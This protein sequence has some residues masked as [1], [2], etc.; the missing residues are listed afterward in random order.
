MMRE[1][2]SEWRE[3]SHNDRTKYA[4]GMRRLNVGCWGYPI[5]N[6]RAV[7]LTTKEGDDNSAYCFSKDL[8]KLVSSFR[9]DGYDLEYCGVLE[10][11][12]VKHLLHWHGL[13]RIA[14]GF[15]VSD[16]LR[17]VR[18]TLGDRWNEYHGAFA[19]KIVPV[20]HTYE[21]EQ[22]IMKHIL[23]EYVGEE[24]EIRNKFL[25]SKGW[26]REGWKEVENLAKSWCLGGGEECGGFSAIFMTKE[27]WD[28]VNEIVK[29]WAEHRTKIFHG[30]RVDGHE[31]GY[32]YMERGRIC[33]VFGSPFVLE[34]NGVVS[35]S[36]FEYLNYIG[37]E[38]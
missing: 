34:R 9:R 18:R 15:F 11:T 27:Y 6:L 22:Y 31:S 33:E 24:V 36:N 17:V 38:L 28:L 30:E 21:L 2:K 16:D 35:V 1:H 20:T 14:G 23:K 12:P 5:G 26:M 13:F 37:S 10:F 32:L 29:A 8:R 4:L 25:F 3:L 7:H 19:V